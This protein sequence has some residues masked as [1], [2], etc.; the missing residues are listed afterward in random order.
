MKTIEE[1]K[2]AFTLR[3]TTAGLE[4]MCPMEGSLASEIAVV[5]EAPGDKECERRSPL[6]GGSGHMLWTSLRTRGISRA[7]CYVTNVSKRM[8]SSYQRSTRSPISKHEFDHWAALLRWELLQL[9]NLRYVLALGN[10]ALEALTGET[11]ITKWRGS[12]LPT[13]IE[14][15]EG[16][17]LLRK[18]VIIVAAN[19]P[20]VVI[21]EPKNELA[22]NLDMHKLKRVIDG[23]HSTPSVEAIINP[24]SEE[25]ISFVRDL[26]ARGGMVSYDIEVMGNQTAC[27]GLADSADRGMCINFRTGRENRYTVDEESDIRLAILE[28][29]RSPKIK[30]IAQNGAFDMSWLWYKDMIKVERTWFDTM[31]AHHTLYPTLPHNLGFICTQYT[32]HPYYKDEKDAWREGGDIDRFW[33]YNVMDCC[34]TFAAAVRMIDELRAQH[35]DGFFFNHVMRLQPHLVRMTVAG[36]KIDTELKAKLGEDL[37]DQINNLSRQYRVAVQEALP[38]VYEPGTEPSPNSPKQLADL[39]FGKLKLVG[40]GTSTDDDNREAMFNHP[41]TPEAARK[42]I[43]LLGEY[44]QEHKFYSTYVTSEVDPDGRIRC[45]YNQSGVQSAPG[46]LSSS[47]VLWGSGMN[48]Q[49]QPERAH[50]M[51]IADPGYCFFYFDLSQAE[52]RMVAYEANIPAWKEQFE[53]ARLDGSYDCHRALASDMFKVPYD[54]VPT[55]DRYDSTKGYVDPTGKAKDGEPT[56]RYIAKRCRHGL[57]Y[58]MGADKLAMV[59]GLSRHAAY[60][61]FDI[62]HKTTPELRDWWAQVEREVKKEK[63]LWNVFG[64]RLIFLERLSQETMESIVAFKPQ[65]AIGDKV[66][67]VIYQVEEDPEWPQ[68]SRIVLNIH[69]ALVGIAPI[70]KAMTCLRI[71]KKHAEAPIIVKGE[72]LIV[73][74]EAGISQ[75]DEKGIHRWSTIKKIKSLEMAA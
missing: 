55:F 65:S 9:P 45:S 26:A 22:F 15:A 14:Y 60:T 1:L 27:I 75:P 41:R 46:R 71:C 73:P 36:I 56:I 58:R 11:G 47:K 42:I 8:V 38:D 48:L 33:R 39:F 3:A 6:I 44:K 57:N 18:D 32:D 64:R 67:Q 34:V 66:S 28:L 23:K 69:D 52:A 62:Y 37:R 30:L 19:N 53:R 54:E 35:L 61:V 29:V 10:M 49:N 7:D 16:T 59:T 63:A 20:A 17:R 31:L 13:T 74:M 51:F 70:E 72:P 4:V 5:A 2:A 50:E 25:A 24:S 40:R 43:R 21:R 12:V 68:D